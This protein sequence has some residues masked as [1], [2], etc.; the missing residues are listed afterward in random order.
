MI[1]DQQ[2]VPDN[3]LELVE[4]I[5]QIHAW[6]VERRGD[7]EIVVEIPARWCTYL[8]YF[9]WRDAAAALH[10][11]CCYD[12]CIPDG[13]EAK[14]YELLAKCNER[15]W[16]GHFGLWVEE[17]MPLFRHT[18]LFSNA[19]TPDVDHFEELIDIGVAECERFFPAFN[20]IIENEISTDDALNGA[21]LE[22]M[23]EA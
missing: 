13:L 22:P 23:G 11:A 15:L 14:T 1:E 4:Q 10:L 21:L 7:E 19:S 18:L 9:T 20:L 12:L 8:V 6:R 16:I 5:A 3:P 2:S 17:R